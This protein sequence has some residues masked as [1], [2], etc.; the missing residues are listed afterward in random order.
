MVLTP[1]PSSDRLNWGPRGAEAPEQVAEFSWRT[2]LLDHAS[3]HSEQ[4]DLNRAV[5]EIGLARGDNTRPSLDRHLSR[6]GLRI[7]TA[8]PRVWVEHELQPKGQMAH[9][10]RTA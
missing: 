4:F 1:Y 6:K 5:A 7:A 2:A 10:I 9:I 3:V 8:L